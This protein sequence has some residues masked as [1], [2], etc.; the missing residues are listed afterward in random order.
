ML[1]ADKDG[2]MAD[3]LCISNDD[4]RNNLSVDLNY[5]LNRLDTQLNKPTH[6]NSIKVSKVVKPTNKKTL[7]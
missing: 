6:Q 1:Q 5:W 2:T 7:L 3:K 4:K